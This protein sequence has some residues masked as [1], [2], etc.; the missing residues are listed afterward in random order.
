VVLV[1]DD[2]P[3]PGGWPLIAWAHGFTGSARRCAPSLMRNLHEGPLLSMYVNL[4]YAVVATDYAG[5]GTSFRNAFI[6]MESNGTDVINSIAAS[7]AA[8]PQLGP[9]WIALGEAEG[10]LAVLGVAELE[11][12]IR[13]PN[14][15]GSIAVSGIADVQDIYKQITQG[16]SPDMLLFL[17]H[18]VQTLYPGFQVNEMLTGKALVLYHQIENACATTSGS[19]VPPNQLLKPGWENNNFIQ[20]FFARNT[21]GR[22]PIYGPLLII[23]SDAGP[24]VNKTVM[25]Q[26]I[27]RVCKQSDKVQFHKYQGSDFGRV[28]GD[29]VSDQLTW[30]QARFSGRPAAGNCQ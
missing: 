16:N 29:S 3:P 11:S 23:S 9:W 2:P 14:Y 17:A 10:G 26:A 30:I 7:R 18:G 8:V 27:A 21:V 22:K 24:A 4:G 5:L 20:Q 19:D 25:A 12:R 6:D 1:P 15:L 28:L 13:D